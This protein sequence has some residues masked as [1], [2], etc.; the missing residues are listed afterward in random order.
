MKVA[1]TKIVFWSRGNQVVY[2]IG[3]PIRDEH[4]HYLEYNHS[5][6]LSN[7][8]EI[9][10]SSKNASKLDSKTKG[11]IFSQLSDLKKSISDIKDVILNLKPMS[12]TT[13]DHHIK[14]ESSPLKSTD[15]K[16]ILV[17]GSPGDEVTTGPSVIQ[18][19][20]SLKKASK[21]NE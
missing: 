21:S 8:L 1:N 20:K 16:D 2:E 13:K 6:R 4:L 7:E 11:S 12:Q 9:K 15:S 14:I 3:D 19:V 17:E 10:S 5:A 18:K